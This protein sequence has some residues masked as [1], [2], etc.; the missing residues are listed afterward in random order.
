VA[1]GTARE[2]EKDMDLGG[3]LVPKGTQCQIQNYAM[4]MSKEYFADPQKWEPERWDRDVG[5]A[6]HPFSSMPFG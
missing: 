4:S 5:K 1:T 3:Y 6:F 2:L